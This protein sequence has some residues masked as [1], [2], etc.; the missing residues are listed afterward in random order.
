MADGGIPRGKTK[1]LG[2]G[3]YG[4][5]VKPVLECKND[6]LNA[7]IRKNQS[8]GKKYVSKIFNTRSDLDETIK[9][10]IRNNVI[11]NL[12]GS[13]A[14][15]VRGVT[16]DLGM[17]AYSCELKTPAFIPECGSRKLSNKSLILTDL[18]DMDAE[19]LKDSKIISSLVSLTYEDI[20]RAV[21]SNLV[22][23]SKLHKA[24]YVN[25]DI[26]LANIIPNY[27]DPF[28][29]KMIDYD[30]LRNKDDEL[31]FGYYHAEYFFPPEYSVLGAAAYGEYF[32]INDTKRTQSQL[33]S[34]YNILVNETLVRTGLNSSKQALYNFI[35]SNKMEWEDTFEDNAEELKNIFKEY[36]RLKFSSPKV[37]ELLSSIDYF[38]YAIAMYTFIDELKKAKTEEEPKKWDDLLE[39]IS[40]FFHPKYSLRLVA[41]NEF[42]DRGTL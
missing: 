7:K 25:M 4:C 2:K 12:A 33:R 28:S 42:L 11:A 35:G 14:A 26:K 8:E 36:E 39:K 6:G 38:M 18:G 3:G 10:N 1:V 34:I 23:I 17:E 40:K 21:I 30:M 31:V 29:F 27:D 37:S 41:I 32:G 16:A 20:E 5:V 22:N 15:K 13:E 19:K 24:G 9:E